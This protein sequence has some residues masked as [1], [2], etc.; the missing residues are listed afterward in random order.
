MRD[1]M[2]RDYVRLCIVR[3]EECPLGSLSVMGK[4]VPPDP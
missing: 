3:A 2:R 1:K 4:S